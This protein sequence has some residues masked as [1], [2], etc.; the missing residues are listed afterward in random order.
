VRFQVSLPTPFAVVSSVVVA[1]A[2]AA[3]EAAYEKAMVAEVAA[4]CRH[5]PHRDLTIQ[6]D[7]CN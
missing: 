7:L 4:L 6:W 3:V 1:D 5:I 2:L